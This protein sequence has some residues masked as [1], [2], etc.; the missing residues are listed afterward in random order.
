LKQKNT[1]LF[2]DPYYLGTKLFIKR[3]C[4]LLKEKKERN[5]LT[6]FLNNIYFYK[7]LYIFLQHKKSQLNVMMYSILEYSIQMKETLQKNY[8]TFII[9]IATTNANKIEPSIWHQLRFDH[10]NSFQEK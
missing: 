3:F 4:A 7:V 8:L 6:N 9:S 10:P 5:H 2:F 1:Y